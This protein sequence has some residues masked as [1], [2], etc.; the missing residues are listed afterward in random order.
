M[1]NWSPEKAALSHDQV[2]DRLAAELARDRGGTT[3][4]YVQATLYQWHGWRK[5]MAAGDSRLQ[6]WYEIGR[7]ERWPTPLLP[8]LKR[9]LPCWTTSP[10]SNC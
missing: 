8:G 1:V 4:R 6:H 7:S 5:Q 9:R 10:T 2:L 3:G